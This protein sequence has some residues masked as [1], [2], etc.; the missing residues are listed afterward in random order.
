MGNGSYYAAQGTV[1][2]CVTLLYN[3]NWRNIVN[4][5]YLNR[6]EKKSPWVI[7]KCRQDWGLWC[8]SFFPLPRHLNSCELK[9]MT[10][11][12]V[13]LGGD[14][15]RFEPT[16]PLTSPNDPSGSP[17]KCLSRQPRGA[18]RGPWLLGT[19]AGTGWRLLQTVLPDSSALKH[20]QREHSPSASQPD[21]HWWWVDF[22]WGQRLP[23]S[24]N[25]G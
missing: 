8:R 21:Q 23:G 17:S 7:L 20:K 5:L 10:E 25:P 22:K 14:R 6:K 2:D 3:R 13:G 11:A 16:P 4:Q 24:S 12:S 1:C 19:L 9:A 15:G 18:A